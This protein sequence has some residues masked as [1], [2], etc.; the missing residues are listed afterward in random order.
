VNKEKQPEEE[1][2]E[3]AVQ[4]LVL[5][6]EMQQPYDLDLSS[7]NADYASY[8]SFTHDAPN[9][10]FFLQDFNELLNTFDGIY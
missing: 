1:E 6:N 7:L 4:D 10:S 3:E 8:L 2:E 9:E 5:S